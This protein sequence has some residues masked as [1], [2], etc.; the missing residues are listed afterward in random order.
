MTRPHRLLALAAVLALAGCDA[1]AGDDLAAVSGTVVNAETSRPITGATVQIRS[2]GLEMRSDS[3]GAF[4]ASLDIDS[5]AVLEVTAFKTGFRD[6]TVTTTVEP[7]RTLSLPALALTPTTGDDGTSGPA[8]S[9]TLAPRS[10]QS[11]G[12]SE[13]GGTETASL[14]FV[15]RDADDRPVDGANAVDITVSILRGPGGGEFLSP[16]APATVRTDENGEASVTLTS[17]TKAGVVQIE[18]RAAVGGREIRSQPITLVVHGGFPSPDHLSVGA[19]QLNYP[20]LGTFGFEIPISALVGD[21]YANPVQ[22]GTQ[23][24]FTS[25]SG[26]IGGSS[27]TD[28]SGRAS[29]T[30]LTGNPSPPG[31]WITVSARTSGADGAPVEADARVLLTGRP[32]VSLE[33]AGLELGT[34]RYVVSDGSGHPLAAGTQISVAVEGQNVVPRGDLD[35]SLVDE[36]RSGPGRTEFQ[37]AVREDDPAG[38]PARVDEILIDVTGPN[39][40]VRAHRV[41]GEAG[42]RRPGVGVLTPGRPVVGT[43]PHER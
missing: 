22:P 13:T 3:V 16:A 33:T 12:V 27:E 4:V 24:Y 25:T 38:D 40:S 6:T 14:V 28:A 11:I 29:V 8:A 39:G 37:F 15:A 23:V 35:V 32:Q 42:A 43:M 34:Y 36:V 31:G 19:D 20:L 9:I 17:G 10:S 30:L 1:L 21:R 41:R 26:V 7:G 5:T 18:T 2:M